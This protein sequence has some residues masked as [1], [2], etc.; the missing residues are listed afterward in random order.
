MQICGGMQCRILF[1]KILERYVEGV[2]EMKG[3]IGTRYLNWKR[4]C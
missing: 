2:K 3:Y 4:S 1:R